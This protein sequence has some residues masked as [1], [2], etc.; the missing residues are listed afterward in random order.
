MLVSPA[1]L[2]PPLAGAPTRRGIDVRSPAEVARGAI[3]DT[4]VLPILEDDERHAVG[5]RYAQEGP[6]AATYEGE[7][8][9][10]EAMPVRA[11]AWRAAAE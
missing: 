8:R 1:E 5:L 11:A 10:R 9:T 6:E 7:A 3:P 2:Y 4:R